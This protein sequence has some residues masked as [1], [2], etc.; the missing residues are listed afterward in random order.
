MKR[1]APCTA[2]GVNGEGTITVDEVI[3]AVG[4]AVEGC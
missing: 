4:A 1:S 3:T 2:G